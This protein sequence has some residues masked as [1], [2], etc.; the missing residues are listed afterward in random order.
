MIWLLGVLLLFGL[1]QS[2][3]GLIEDDSN[4]GTSKS[5]INR[6]LSVFYICGFII[7][8]ITIIKQ[9]KET[10]AIN[11]LNERMFSSVSKIDSNSIKQLQRINEALNKTQILISKSDSI[12]KRTMSILEEKDV[13]LTQYEKVN[14]R[15]SKQLDLETKLFEANSPNL[16]LKD[17]DISWVSRDSISYSLRA[18]VRNFG[19][20]VASINEGHG[21]VL[22]FDE[23]NKPIASIKIPGNKTT[24]LLEANDKENMRLC[25]FSNSWKAPFD[26]IK[27]ITNFAIVGLKIDYKD[28]ATNRDTI[29]HFYRGWRPD[30]GFGGLKNWQTELAR[31]WAIEYQIFDSDSYKSTKK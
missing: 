16:D 7:G 25:F 9:E 18:C 14:K 13:L 8:I 28:L 27:A 2:L 23:A 3:L 4:L 24:G 20:R 26:S 10:S 6:I 15:L 21:F 30:F 22:F 11:R 1:I 29:K 31:K 12:D 17:Y 19:Q 5:K